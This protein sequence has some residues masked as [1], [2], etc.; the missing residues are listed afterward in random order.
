MGETLDCA[1]RRKCVACAH[2]VCFGVELPKGAKPNVRPEMCP[3]AGAFE[4]DDSRARAKGVMGLIPRTLD[5]LPTKPMVLTVG[6]GDLSFS[7]AVASW[8]GGDCVVA[9]TFESRESVLASYPDTAPR[10]LDALRRA[11]ATILHGVDASDLATT[12]VPKLHRTTQFDFIVFNFPCIAVRSAP[13]L[14]AQN[15]ER[16][17][18]MELLERFGEGA[19]ALLAPHSHARVLVSH[20][21]KAAFG[22]WDVPTHLCASGSLTPLGAVVFDRCCYP[23][24][25]NRKALDRKSFPVSD[26]VTFAFGLASVR[27]AADDRDP[28]QREPGVE[29]TPVTPSLVSRIIEEALT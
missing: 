7:A 8:L 26:A 29:T 17:A 16:D 1:L 20:K 10:I 19:S 18:N 9:T 21:T 22:T 2:K 23:G 12:L 24:Y 4:R 15:A 14:D 6:D 28:H 25:T 27:A 3:R 11:N 13:G 5:P